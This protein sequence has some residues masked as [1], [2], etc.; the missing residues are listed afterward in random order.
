MKEDSGKEQKRIRSFTRLYDLLQFVEVGGRTD[1]ILILLERITCE[2]QNFSLILMAQ[3]ARKCLNIT[4]WCHKRQQKTT[5]ERSLV[6]PAQ[7]LSPGTNG[8]SQCLQCSLSVLPVD[9]GICDADT[10]LETGLALGG[11]LLVAY[12]ES[13]Q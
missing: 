10:V 7:F 4:S 11:N 5:Q 1:F 9:A 8:L 13:G 3:Y 2:D 12:I 6:S